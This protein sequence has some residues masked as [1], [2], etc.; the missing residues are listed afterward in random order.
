MN[1]VVGAVATTLSSFTDGQAW[2]S[3]RSCSFSSIVLLFVVILVQMPLA[4]HVQ[5][6][7]AD[8]G[9]GEVEG[10][11]PLVL[12]AT[13]RPN[14]IARVP[15]VAIIDV[16][17][18]TAVRA[19]VEVAT[20]SRRW[21]Q[22]FPGPPST[23]FSF[24]VMG[25]SPDTVHRIE[26][27]VH[28]TEGTERQTLTPFLFRTPP[29]PAS[30][31]PLH[32]TLARGGKME[33]GVTLF[34]VNLWHESTSML[35]YGFII[36]VDER[37][38]VVY[39]CHTEDRIADMRVLSNGNI[40]YQHGSYRY[41]YEIDLLG[42]D[43]HRW[44]ATNLTELPDD[45]SI[46]VEVDTM[47]HDLL[48]LPNGN[49]MTLATELRH[50][51]RYPTSEFDPHAPWAPA[52]VVCDKVVEFR[53]QTGEIVDELPLTE[54]LDRRRFGYM[55][56]TT[57]WKDKYEKLLPEPARD[58]SHANGLL[59]LPAENCIIVS[60]RHLDCVMK[61]DW[62]SKQI[63]WILGD[64]EGWGDAWQAYLL[65]PQGKLRWFY[66]QH[67]PQITPR[68]TLLL[69]DNGNYRARPFHPPVLA[70]HNRSRVVEL[71][72]DEQA[73]TVRQLFE[74]SGEPDA[75]F[76]SPFYGE[77]DWLPQTHNLLITD[78]GRIELADGTPHD[79]V[80]GEHQW[81]RIFEI[82]RD[83]PPEKVFEVEVDSGLGSQYGW[84]IYRAMRV[85]NLWDGFHL[86]APG[87]DEPVQVFQ[88]ERH[89][90]KLIP[91]LDVLTSP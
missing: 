75:P 41:A 64:P 2:A 19:E 78:G 1:S 53:P 7:Q 33:P 48:E 16:R 82:T 88:R 20:G 73:M 22:P 18:S 57:F 36:G 5:A 70:P 85:P 50:F 47:H 65:K 67:A 90:S 17:T 23:N 10:S 6:V 89:E 76:Y 86:D 59:Y 77:A 3:A 66:H 58:W 25:L 80:P 51:E 31:P 14:P 52:Y 55:A 39:Y 42:R 29:L 79:D 40:L 35:D 74:Y 11:Q 37:G 69:F 84:S 68:G 12:S 83:D 54:L 87:V 15:L 4:C 71:G 27:T 46:G 91:E 60:F 44:V 24:P 62:Q 32:T 49:F 38:E 26:L 34:A 8:S 43:Y 81:A 56:L 13:M 21:T 9:R 61:I 30:F 28:A 45:Q 63:R 72:I